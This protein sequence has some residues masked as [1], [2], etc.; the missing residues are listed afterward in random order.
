MNWS[1]AIRDPLLLLWFVLVALLAAGMVKV[2]ADYGT[3][4]E[5]R[6]TEVQQRL[7]QVVTERQ[8]AVE[9]E[10]REAVVAVEIARRWQVRAVQLA[11]FIERQGFS[12]PKPTVVL[13]DVPPEGTPLPE[14]PSEPGSVPTPDVLTPI[15][16]QST[17]EPPPIIPPTPEPETTCI[18]LPTLPDFCFV[19]PTPPGP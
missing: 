1:R 11:R 2:V 13:R 3:N 14:E 6:G 18:P 19:P 10:Q 7:R 17:L 12:V 5:A 8:E 9:Q 16:E 15:P 4:I